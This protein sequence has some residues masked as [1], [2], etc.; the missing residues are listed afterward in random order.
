[1]S[2][3]NNPY[4]CIPKYITETNDFFLSWSLITKNNIKYDNFISYYDF[5]I[6]EFIIKSNN[7]LD[8][9]RFKASIKLDDNTQQNS[10]FTINNIYYDNIDSGIKKLTSFTYQES[11]KNNS[12]ILNYTWYEVHQNITI[13]LIPNIDCSIKPDPEPTD[14]KSMKCNPKCSQ[15][16]D[17]TS[18]KRCDSTLI[19][20]KSS[21]LGTINWSII[22]NN[23]R[24]Y[25]GFSIKYEK[26]NESGIV[27]LDVN[28]DIDKNFKMSLGCIKFN[29][30]VSFKVNSINDTMKLGIKED[31]AF[32]FIDKDN[33]YSYTKD[34]NIK[35]I[36]TSC[37]NNN[38]P[39]PPYPPQ[40]SF[41]PSSSTRSLKTT[42][43][44]KTLFF[45]IGILF[46]IT[47]LI[48]F[49]YKKKFF[50]LKSR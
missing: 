19:S 11:K 1:M 28:N 7:T 46:L 40:S 5:T 26:T 6:N 47:G 2:D 44:I 16:L 3:I 48:L 13:K 23:G 15:I 38:I 22:S 14:D 12:D 10:S 21:Y 35:I 20:D 24:Q 32:E 37:I 4:L 30:I 27:Y 31:Y 33:S 8:D 39:Y 25:D 17:I 29:G 41:K 42:Y 45:I 34:N 9:M 36:P 18:G 50:K 43:S 49:F